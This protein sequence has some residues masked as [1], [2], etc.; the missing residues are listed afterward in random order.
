MKQKKPDN[1]VFLSVG[2][3]CFFLIMVLIC[4]PSVSGVGSRMTVGDTILK[5][6]N[7]RNL[8][9][10]D[11]TGIS[12]GVIS[13]GVTH[14]ADAQASGDLPATVTVLS[15]A[16]KGDEGT[17]MLEIIHDIAPNASL[18][19][20]DFGGNEDGFIVAIDALVASGVQI[21]VD[22]VGWQSDPF[23]QDGVV[24]THIRELLKQYPYL[25]YLSSAGNSG[26][27]HYQGEF[28]KGPDGYHLFGDSSGIGVEIQPGGFITA[29]LEWDDPWGG[30]KNDYDLALID[31]DSNTKISMS[32]RN[33]TGSEDPHERMDYR[34]SGNKTVNAEIRVSAKEGAEPKNIELFLYDRPDKTTVHSDL[35]TPEDSIH[36]QPAVPEVISVTAVAPSEL[37]VIQ[38]FSSQ[39]EITI[40]YPAS[41][42]RQKPD[43]TGIDTIDVSGAGGFKSPFTGTS[44]AA[45]HITGLIAL[46]WSLFPGISTELIKKA[47]FETA[48]DLG[49]PGWDNQF[50]N[51]LPDAVK[52]YEYL[53]ANQGNETGVQNVSSV[54]IQKPGK[55][56]PGTPSVEPTPPAQDENVI[57]GP[58]IISKP[59]KYTLGKDIRDSSPVIISIITSGVE[60]N[61]NGHQIDGVGV[62]I[63]MEDPIL[64]TGIMALSP[65]NERL[66]G[67][68]V[69]GVTV[70]GCYTGIDF[71]NIE[72][73]DVNNC[74]LLYN[75]DG[76]LLNSTGAVTITNNEGVGNSNSGILQTG[77]SIGSIISENR[78]IA[79][80]NGISLEGGKKS[81]I[82]NNT[83][84]D[85]A[86]SGI[87][88][89]HGSEENSISGNQVS[90]NKDGGISL[91]SSIKNTINQNS[92][93]QNNLWGILLHESSGNIIT[94]NILSDNLRG[95]NLYYADGN[96]ISGNTIEEN[97]ATGIFFNP[98][99][100]NTVRDNTI[101]SNEDEGIM[102]GSEVRPNVKNLIY[103]NII[104]NKNNF[105]VQ[106]GAKPNYVWNTEKAEGKNIVGGDITGGNMW[107]SPS[108]AG[109]SQMCTDVNNDGLCDGAYEITS[110]NIDQFPLR[111]TAA[112]KNVTSGTGET[113]ASS[114]SGEIKVP[115]TA[116][117]WV[118]EGKSLL[119]RADYEGALD[120]FKKALGLTPNHYQALRDIALVYTKMEKFPEAVEAIDTAIEKYPEST[121]LWSTKGDI[122]LNNMGK[123]TEAVYS[124][125]KALN[126]DPEDVH[127]L[128]NKA[129]ALD[130]N[131][132]RE[133]AYALY[134]KA[135]EINPQ[136]SD[137]WYK[138]G[139]LLTKDG[140]FAEALPLYEK[141][142]AIDPASS[143]SW[144][145]KGYALAQLGD[146]D[147]AIEA[148]NQA[149]TLDPAYSTAWKN[150]GDAYT[151]TGKT[152]EA[153]EAYSH[154]QAS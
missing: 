35:L 62:R 37:A 59:G 54:S 97:R 138:A 45:P 55:I 64:Q 101:S 87:I 4:I 57:T 56:Y 75:A 146:Y 136:L 48:Q 142:I 70:T 67:I 15:N 98:S 137:A 7:L 113:V 104:S 93:K 8:T 26:N 103:N 17:A 5:T 10:A 16:R 150:L 47:L 147:K 20:H 84:T 99:G 72:S 140:R 6:D 44:A 49:S 77:N 69:K 79:G 19:F 119:D 11:G 63:G 144:N 96:V 135:L 9:G 86:L 80:L 66:T 68:S 38:D 148:Y 51:G 139:N 88:L 120:A 134:M 24:A 112:P 83:I 82:S 78:I 102:I 42:K 106:E 118:E 74:R 52:M 32:E 81:T 40:D 65:D 133:E 127:S 3:F 105:L 33:Q 124:Y 60:I 50:G 114:E 110:G 31:K 27:L 46:E 111:D 41:E 90:G 151:K 126:I 130:K 71:S 117:E 53:K 73:G 152:K 143:Y 123:I 141:A 145:N 58:V 108:G 153:E 129:F 29:I 100:N 2:F 109:Y 125:D 95:L 122:Y 28:V 25:I 30:S 22:D 23:Y 36:G 13:D 92:C 14:I 76:I 61:G 121:E 21:I 128:V 34:N 1:N 149:I 94:Q 85:N 131:G 18:F 43:I 154:T 91:Y 116:D 115:L 107:G 89:T 39:G 12:I 132:K